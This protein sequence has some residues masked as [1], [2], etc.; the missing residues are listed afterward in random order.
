MIQC[1][2]YRRPYGLLS[3]YIQDL[4]AILLYIMLA[5]D[6]M[7]SDKYRSFTSTK[8]LFAPVQREVNRY[9]GTYS[10][11]GYHIVQSLC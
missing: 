6:E 4:G 10:H 2:V 1:L 11:T 3:V 8:W 7:Q 5:C 9:L